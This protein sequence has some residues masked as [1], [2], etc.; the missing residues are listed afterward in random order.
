MGTV[1]RPE[2]SHKNTYYISKHRYYELKHFCLQYK[3]WKTLC[4]D[5]YGIGNPN[6]PRVGFSPN[7]SDPIIWAVE[8]R[9]EYQRKMHMVENA[10]I[11]ASPEL[12]DY[13]LKAVTEGLKYENLKMVYDLPCG[14]EMWYELY[15][16]FFY[17]L[18]SS[19]R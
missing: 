7:V 18:S 4:R 10:A 2:V 14:R 8:R 3:T 5:I 17:I 19:R 6:F 16:K 1:I 11:A 12:S 9:E 15:R 13:I